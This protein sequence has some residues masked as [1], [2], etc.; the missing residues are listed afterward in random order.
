MVIKAGPRGKRN[1]KEARRLAKSQRGTCDKDKMPVVAVVERGNKI[2]PHRNVKTKEI[3]D[4]TDALSSYNYPV[5][6]H[7]SINHN[8]DK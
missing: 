8:S 7:R 1:M 4:N 6:R 3:I 5:N 2:R